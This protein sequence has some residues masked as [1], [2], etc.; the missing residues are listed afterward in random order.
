MDGLGSPHVNSAR[1]GDGLRPPITLMYRWCQWSNHE[2][3]PYVPLQILDGVLKNYLMSRPFVSPLVVQ[4]LTA[5]Q[6]S[7]GRTYIPSLG[8]YLTH[9]WIDEKLASAKASKADDAGIPTHMWDMRITK[10]FPSL[11]TQLGEWGTHL[12]IGTEVPRTYL[13]FFRHRL[14]GLL[15][16]KIWKELR[17][18]LALIHGPNWCSD[19]LTIRAAIAEARRSSSS[20][21]AV[22]RKRERGG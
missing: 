17:A 4:G 1:M 22:G 7:T 3:F 18:Y 9:E 5:V 15:R 6:A 19:L 8:R 20:P 14:M 21:I 13:A 11:A 2:C 16:R 10:L 12:W